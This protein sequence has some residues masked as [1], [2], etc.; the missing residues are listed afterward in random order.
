MCELCLAGYRLVNSVVRV[1][2]RIMKVPGLH[3]GLNIFHYVEKNYKIS[4]PITKNIQYN[5]D[6][7]SRVSKFYEF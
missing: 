4:Q 2:V 5:I 6:G 3:P 1:L 7:Y